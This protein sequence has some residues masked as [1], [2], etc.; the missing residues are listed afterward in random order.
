[1]I[2][3][4]L[5]KLASRGDQIINA[6][7]FERLGLAT[8]FEEERFDATALLKE[9]E[10]ILEGPKALKFKTAFE[11][12]TPHENASSLISKRLFSFLEPR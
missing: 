5:G 9:V 10:E 6:G 2:L 12:Q 4:P 11:R 1:M 7:I 8:V 3:F